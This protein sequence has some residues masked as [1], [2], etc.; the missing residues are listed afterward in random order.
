MQYADPWRL[1]GAELPDDLNLGLDSITSWVP[2]M[3]W[4]TTPFDH[5]ITLA[6]D[7]ARCMPPHRDQGLNNAL[8]DTANLVEQLVAAQKVEKTP[9]PRSRSQACLSQSHLS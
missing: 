6:G 2:S 4:F 3:D 8:Q 7:A 1:V 5:H 9:T